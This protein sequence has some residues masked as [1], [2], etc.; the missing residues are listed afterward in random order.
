MLPANVKTTQDL[1]SIALQAEREAIRRYAELSENMKAANNL[2]AADLFKRLIA[3]EEEHET[4]LLA[5][6]AKNN[7]QENNDIAP[8]KWQD[9]NIPTTYNAEARDP[10]YSTPYRALAFAVHNEEI[11]FRFYTHVAANAKTQEMREYAET[12][13]RE[14][15]G[16][17]ALLRAERRRAYHN[18]K[19]SLLE[20]RIKADNVCT[21][22]DLLTVATTYEKLIL[23]LISTSTFEIKPVNALVDKLQQVLT[24]HNDTLSNL[25]SQDAAEVSEDI[26]IN[27]QQLQA[28]NQSVSKTLSSAELFIKRLLAYCDHAF[29]FYDSVVATTKDESIMLTAQELSANALDCID[30]L[31]PRLESD[32]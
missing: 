26:L 32:T 29:S 6:M 17:A 19:N 30:V 12:L 20:P 5:W 25:S 28:F 1:L 22:V 15:L 4:L 9:P 7:I 27:L 23:E 18:E 31:R 11:A 21:T 16:H 8:V 24:S 2:S 14:E 3:E 10:S 13:A